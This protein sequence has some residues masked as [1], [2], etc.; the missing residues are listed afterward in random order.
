M[1]SCGTQESQPFILVSSEVKKNPPA[2][3]WSGC[4][5]S[6]KTLET[7]ARGEKPLYVSFDGSLKR[8]T[9]CWRCLPQQTLEEEPSVLQYLLYV[10]NGRNQHVSLTRVPGSQLNGQFQDNPNSNACPICWK[11][12]PSKTSSHYRARPSWPKHLR[13][14]P[15]HSASAVSRNSCFS[16]GILMWKETLVWTLVFK[17]TVLTTINCSWHD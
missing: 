2:H 16:C 15:K 9:M 11:S 13:N 8:T 4:A 10:F 5:S 1:H 14:K 12:P 6:I 3:I 7:H 17:L